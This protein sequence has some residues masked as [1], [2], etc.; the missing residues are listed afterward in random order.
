MNV[1]NLLTTYILV[2]FNYLNVKKSK[3]SE[4]YLTNVS[5]SF[6]DTKYLFHMCVQHQLNPGIYIWP[7]N[8]HGMNP[9]HPCFVQL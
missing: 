1:M 8:T 9:N 4:K 7:A 2:M 5:R 6:P 3:D